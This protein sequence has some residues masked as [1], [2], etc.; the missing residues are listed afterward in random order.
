MSDT[1]TIRAEYIKRAWVAT[2]VDCRG[3]GSTPDKAI[4]AAKRNYFDNHKTD[5]RWVGR[6][7]RLRKILNRPPLST[8]AT[9]DTITVVLDMEVRNDD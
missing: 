9:W 2:G 8:R 5:P 6:T 3:V 1:L 4:T 7:N